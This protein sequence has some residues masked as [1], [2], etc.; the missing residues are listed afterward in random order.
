VKYIKLIILL[1]I[2]GSCSTNKSVVGLYGKC[3][4]KYLACNQIELKA[5]KTFEYFVFMDVGGGTVVKG[6]WEQI[7][8]DSI[9]LNTFDQPKQPTTTYVGKIDSSKIDRVKIKISDLYYPLQYASVQ[10]N[11]KDWKVTDRNGVAE[12]NSSNIE[13]IYYQYLGKEETIEIDNPNYDE[14]EI[15]ISDL[16]MTAVQRFFTDE[17]MV[18]KNKKLYYNEWFS[19]KKTN[20]NQKQWE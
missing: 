7:S 10:I 15:T 4:K 20:L 14:I 18:V 11:G 5:D 8:K 19:L 12:F 16:D 3:G 17:I 1:L 9:K 6:N 13:S 2:C